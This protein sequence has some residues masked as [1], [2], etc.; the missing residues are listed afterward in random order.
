MLG[1]IVGVR[2]MSDGLRN[3]IIK[4]EGERDAVRCWTT[5]RPFS[6]GT[7]RCVRRTICP[8]YSLITALSTFLYSRYHG[9][10]YASGRSRGVAAYLGRVWADGG[11]MGGICQL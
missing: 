10:P 6:P 7:W 5:W 3:Y 1:S 8:M 2:A 11:F 4:G 9:C